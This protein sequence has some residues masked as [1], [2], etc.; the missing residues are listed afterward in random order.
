VTATPL[1]FLVFASGAPTYGEALKMSPAVAAEAFLS[2][3]EHGAI[4]QIQP[5]RTSGVPGMVGLELVERPTEQPRGCVRRRWSVNFHYA[6]DWEPSAALP[7]DVYSNAEIASRGPSGCPTEGYAL[8]NPGVDVDH[9][10]AALA[11]LDDLRNGRGSARIS[12]AD[13]S[14]VTPKICD[15]VQ[16]TRQELVRLR[17]RVV[18]LEH[19]VSVVWLGEG[20]Q[21]EVW[22]DQGFEGVSVRR[23]IPDPF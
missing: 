20:V 9:G 18:T 6:V 11:R 2:G 3:E 8:L 4:G 17:A 7:N 15:S 23:H 12:C 13:T 5:K 19:G 1:L 22:F 21:T 16:A 10:F 14:G